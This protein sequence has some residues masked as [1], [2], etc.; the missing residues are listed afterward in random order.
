VNDRLT[1][2]YTGGR[3]TF[4]TAFYGIYDPKERT[5]TYACAG[6]NPP[7]LKRCTDG[8]VAALDQVRG[9][10]LGI[11]EEVK[12]GDHVER[13]SAG[14]IVLF[15]TD[16]ITEA[17][18]KNGEMFGIQR[19]ERVLDRCLATAEGTVNEVLAE[20]EWFSEGR[21]ASDDRTLLAGQVE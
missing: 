14:D 1:N 19:L 11:E 3:G 5:I 10:P 8:S 12:Y 2:G 21:A 13:L 20:V 18:S 4:V 7:R 15:Y 9:L 16:G 17:W 6:H